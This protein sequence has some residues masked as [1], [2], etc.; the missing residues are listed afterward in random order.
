MRL[1]K[2][3]ENRYVRTLRVGLSR[4][5]PIQRIS[6]EDQGKLDIASPRGR[7]ANAVLAFKSKGVVKFMTA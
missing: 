6:V 2:K 3:T 5:L 1:G 7:P 4:G